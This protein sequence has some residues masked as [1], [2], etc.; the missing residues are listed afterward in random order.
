[1]F[2]ESDIYDPLDIDLVVFDLDGTIADTAHLVSNDARRRP[3][4]ILKFSGQSDTT[5]PLL[6]LH[7]IRKI[8]NDLIQCGV[9]IAVITNSPRAYASTL[10]FLLGIDFDVLIAANNQ[11]GTSSKIQKLKWLSSEGALTIGECIDPARVLY[12]GDRLDDESAAHAAGCKFQWAPNSQHEKPSG[13][14]LQWLAKFCDYVL[15]SRANPQSQAKNARLASIHEEYLASQKGTLDWFVSWSDPL[16]IDINGPFAIYDPDEIPY[17]FNELQ[18]NEA[19]QRPIIDPRF[20][21]RYSYE[22]DEHLR[23][24][25]FAVLHESL[26]SRQINSGSVSSLLQGIEIHSH[27]K[28]WSNHLAQDLWKQVKNWHNLGSGSEVELLHLE[29]VALCMAASIHDRGQKSVIVPMPSSQFSEAKPGRVSNRLAKRVSEILD[30]PFFELFIKDGNNDVEAHSRGYPF[31]QKAI[32]IDDQITDGNLSVKCVE[33]MGLLNIKNFE[34]RTWS[35]SK[36]FPIGKSEN[37]LKFLRAVRAEEHR[38]ESL[39]P[40]DDTLADWAKP[41]DEFNCSRCFLVQ[42][43][44]RLAKEVLGQLICYDCARAVQEEKNEA[45]LNESLELL[46]DNFGLITE[47]VIPKQADEFNCS[48]CFLVHHR[49]RLAKEVLG[50]LICNDCA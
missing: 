27:L 34:I 21:T 37:S 46:G 40:S 10:C 18:P 6:N 13:S 15:R 50:Q 44:S 7:G 47:L 42:H 48:R 19:I 36:F 23:D 38:A 1:M 35:A 16:E 30:Y 33:I 22:N 17:V 32:L 31:T 45:D 24:R 14:P 49:S 3:Y 25:L 11:E 4:D 9:R 2:Q 28:Y 29:F 8:C 39:R 5:T 12:V 43:R 41:A 20:M 26:G